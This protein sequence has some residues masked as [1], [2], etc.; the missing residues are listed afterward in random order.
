M[1]CPKCGGVLD[2][3]FAECPRCG[4]VVEKFLR[5]HEVSHQSTVTDA[6]QV[7]PDADAGHERLVRAA[8]IPGALLLARSLVQTSHG[9]V[10]LITMWV[11]E[12]GHAVT[13]WLCGFPAFPGPWVTS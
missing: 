13:A 12:S 6:P 8:A 11:H 1:E 4:I 7:Q 2:T 10:R 3:D 5:A 9:L